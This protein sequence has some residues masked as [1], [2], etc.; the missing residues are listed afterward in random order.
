[1]SEEIGYETP[2]PIVHSLLTVCTVRTGVIPPA[3]PVAKVSLIVDSA[4]R[5]SHSASDTGRSSV[6]RPRSL[7]IVSMD[8]R[9][10]PGRIVSDN[11][12][13]TR[14]LDP[15]QREYVEELG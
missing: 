13:V 12:G 10:I 5:R 2:S 15:V 1:M 14:W 9:V 11:G 4:Q 3:V 8:R 7:A 6:D